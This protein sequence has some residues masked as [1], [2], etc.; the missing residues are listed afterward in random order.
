[1]TDSHKD[2]SIG[3]PTPALRSVR[4]TTGAR[5]HFGLADTVSPFGGVGLMIDRPQTELIASIADQFTCDPTIASRVVPIAQR[6]AKFAGLA[7]VPPCCV[8]VKR[9]AES[10][11]GLGSGTQLALAAAEA[12]C[13]C[14]GVEVTATGLVTELAMRAQRSAVGAHGYFV[15]GLIFE[16][17]ENDGALNPIRQHVSVPGQW[18]VAV[19]RPAGDAPCVSG[20]YEQRQFFSLMPANAF[21]AA[22][23]DELANDLVRAAQHGDFETF[24]DAVQHYNHQCG[25]L[26]EPV[27]GGPYNGRAVSELVNRLTDRGIR[28]VGQSSWGPGVFAWFESRENA[29]SLVSALPPETKLIALAQPMNRARRV[30]IQA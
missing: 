28:G 14:V 11:C 7:D 6:I 24:A 29:L 3:K 9:R 12:I 8:E 5:L 17:A 18:C 16:T 22:R 23:I 30:E 1:M 19:L 26:F 4:I 27:Q 25:L 21:V 2:L 10:H 15:G 13:R 20:E